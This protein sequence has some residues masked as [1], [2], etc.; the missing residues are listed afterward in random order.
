MEGLLARHITIYSKP[1]VLLL[2]ELIHTLANQPFFVAG[3]F[4]WHVER[5]WE[6]PPANKGGND[7]FTLGGE[8]E[9]KTWIKFFSRTKLADVG[10]IKWQF[11]TDTFHSIDLILEKPIVTPYEKEGLETV[12][13]LLRQ[14]FKCQVSCYNAEFAPEAALLKKARALS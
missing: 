14:V 4:F 1:Q 2:M 10:K 7:W 13:E 3:D 9:K 5:E 11:N 6:Y 8:L 12:Q